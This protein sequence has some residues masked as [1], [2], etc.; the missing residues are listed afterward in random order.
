M[1]CTKCSKI[2]AYFCSRSCYLCF[3]SLHNKIIRVQNIIKQH[4]ASSIYC[5]ILLTILLTTREVLDLRCI[6]IRV[7]EKL[8]ICLC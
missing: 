3:S 4:P 6:T 5:K 2:I 7:S 1:I 8:I